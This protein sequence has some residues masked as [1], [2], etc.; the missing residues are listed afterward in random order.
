MNQTFWQI[1]W[2]IVSL[3]NLILFCLSS[4]GLIRCNIASGAVKVSAEKK[5]EVMAWFA[6]GEGYTTEMHTGALYDTLAT[7]L[8]GFVLFLLIRVVFH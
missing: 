8:I 3:L 7:G 5:A 4:W 2:L 1:A 6:L